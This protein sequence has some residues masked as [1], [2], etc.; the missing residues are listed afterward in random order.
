M[1][2]TDLGKF[3]KKHREALGLTQT[4]LGE[5]LG[6]TQSAVSVLER[7]GKLPAGGDVL[8]KLSETLDVTLHSLAVY[9]MKKCNDVEEALAKDPILNRKERM[10][11]LAAYG[12]LT[13]RE[14]EQWA[15]YVMAD[16]DPS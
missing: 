6:I 2:V 3:V 4:Q 5:Q 16:A 10:A 14:S 1:A 11:L 15:S 8:G 9:V 12:R 7:Q 13:G